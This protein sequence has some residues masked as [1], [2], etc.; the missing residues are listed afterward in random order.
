MRSDLTDGPHKAEIEY[1]RVESADIYCRG[2]SERS[3]LSHLWSYITRSWVRSAVPRTFSLLLF[4]PTMATVKIS[5]LFL[6]LLPLLSFSYAA[7]TCT[8]SPQGSG[9]DDAPNF[10][11][12]IKS[13]SCSTV[14]IP[15]GATLNI[16]SAMDL[17]GLQNKHIVSIF[18]NP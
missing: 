3:I 6:G 17:T 12:M 10:M 8:V 1:S 15:A 11:T 14:E 13:S 18:L 5:A 16:S 4:L 2:S 7:S 9:K